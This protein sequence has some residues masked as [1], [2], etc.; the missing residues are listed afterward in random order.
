MSTKTELT[1]DQLLALWGFLQGESRRYP[2]LFKEQGDDLT[3]AMTTIRTMLNEHAREA[4][5][6]SS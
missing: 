6:A 3:E 5:C 2:T 4:V 1:F